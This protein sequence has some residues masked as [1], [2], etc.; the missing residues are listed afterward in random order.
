MT[1]SPDSNVSQQ[2]D[3]I[4]AKYPD[5]RGQMLSQIRQL[6]KQA[7][8]E[9]IEQIKWR[10]PSNPDGIPVWSN[11]GIICNGET[12]QKHLR[13]SFAKGELLNNPHDLINSYRAIIIHQDDQLDPTA[14]KE[15]IQAAVQ[16]NKQ[17]AKK[18]R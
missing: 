7:D 2:I 4:I 9:V 14:F 13:I 15:L 12:Y 3:K 10:T 18:S 11:N 17:H 16:Y 8:P 6:I 5:W 1:A